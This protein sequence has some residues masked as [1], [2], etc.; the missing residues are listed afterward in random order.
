MDD[1]LFEKLKVLDPK[2]KI[3]RGSTPENTSDESVVQQNPTA[4]ALN[5][6]STS[7]AEKKPVTL[8]SV[9]LHQIN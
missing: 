6:P 9:I 1:G 4:I 8:F 5:L 3:L 2:W 7:N